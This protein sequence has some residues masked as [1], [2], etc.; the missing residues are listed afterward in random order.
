[1]HLIDG[2]G[3]DYHESVELLELKADVM[4]KIRDIGEV[5][6]DE[7]GRLLGEGACPASFKHIPPLPAQMEE[8]LD[9]L[10]VKIGLLIKNMIELDDVVDQAKSMSD[11]HEKGNKTEQNSGLK[12]LKKVG[13]ALFCKRQY[14]Q[15]QHTRLSAALSRPS[16]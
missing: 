16:L 14:L 10:D 6:F 12:A 5:W 13:A 11:M 15:P 2:G 8:R 1:M 3:R 7:G 4:T 9:D